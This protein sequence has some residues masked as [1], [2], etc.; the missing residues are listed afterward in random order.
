MNIDWVVVSVLSSVVAMI[1]GLGYFI[2]FAIK[3]INEDKSND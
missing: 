2:H 3:Q 1:L